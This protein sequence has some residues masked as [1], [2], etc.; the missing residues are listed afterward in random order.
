[1][2][3]QWNLRSNPFDTSPIS[4]GTL[5][6][7]V[8]REAEVILCRRLAAQQK[9]VLVVEGGIGSGT[10][11]FGNM[12][13]FGSGVCTP[14]MEIAVYR[15]W[16]AQILLENVLVAV[17]REVWRDPSSHR[18][19]TVRELYS[20]VQRVEQTVLSGGMTIMGTGG[21]AGGNIA[22]TQPGI[23]P[24]ETLRAGLITLAE[25]HRSVPDSSAF[26]IQLNNLDLNRTFSADELRWFLNEIRDSLQLPGFSWLLVGDAGLNHFITTDVPRIASIVAH[27]VR[28]L[29]LSDAEFIQVVKKRIHACSLDGEEG[30]SPFDED[31]FLRIYR[32]AGGSLRDAFNICSKLCLAVA[33]SPLYE[34]ITHREAEQIL[35]ELQAPRLR[36]IKDNPLQHAILIE[37]GDSPGI[38]QKQLVSI[39]KKQQPAVSRA[40]KF[41]YEA[42]LIRSEKEGVSTCYR[43]APEIAFALPKR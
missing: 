12:V 30:V 32:A 10:T 19:S 25:N 17:I 24:L 41:L 14:R 34:T 20:L 6:W 39:L 2:F 9:S 33:K 35:A 7:F 40:L 42:D 1:M 23:V 38:N 3:S 43:L 8:G 13:R 5:D 27:D 15:A 37:I 28:I 4:L 36:N 31:L 16:T 11:S 22:V 26:V 21:H 29:P 18:S